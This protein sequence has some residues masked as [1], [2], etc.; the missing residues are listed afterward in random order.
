MMA[1]TTSRSD[2]TCDIPSQCPITGKTD[3]VLP[4][5]LLIRIILWLL[6]FAVFPLS[7]TAATVS[8]N[9]EVLGRIP[10]A[11][12]PPGAPCVDVSERVLVYLEKCERKEF[13]PWMRDDIRIAWITVLEASRGN[14]QPHIDA[15]YKV[16]GIHPAKVWP[17][18][19][20]R[21]AALLGS[22]SPC[23]ETS[24][25]TAHAPVK[26]SYKVLT[27]PQCAS[28]GQTASTEM[29]RG[30]GMPESLA[31]SLSG[32]GRKQNSEKLIKGSPARVSLNEFID[33]PHNKKQPMAANRDG[34]APQKTCAYGAEAD[35]LTG[36]SCRT[37]TKREARRIRTSEFGLNDAPPAG[38]AAPAVITPQKKK[39]KSVR[40]L[41]QE[42]VA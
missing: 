9:L 7:V 13:D 33:I 15:T 26:A 6:V 41:A 18:I 20:A 16:L 3:F 34:D 10:Y 23:G 1:W 35:H 39:S 24:Q 25:S 22:E 2:V 19:C 5:P 14:P 30:L 17:A 40:N 11:A 28:S 29:T 37:E 31:G 12:L 4:G 21:R 27:L 42:G 36:S 8:F 38:V 32:S